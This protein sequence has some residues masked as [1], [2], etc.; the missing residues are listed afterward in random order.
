MA[1]KVWDILSADRTVVL[2]NRSLCYELGVIAVDAQTMMDDF[3]KR[4]KEFKHK[5]EIDVIY[6]V[7]GVLDEN[8]SQIKGDITAAGSRGSSFQQR[9]LKL[10]FEKDLNDEKSKF[11]QCQSKVYSISLSQ[12]YNTPGEES[13]SSEGKESAVTVKDK[14]V[15]ISNQL[16]ELRRR[17]L[18]D[19]DK[20]NFLSNRYGSIHLDTNNKFEDIS[21]LKA[22]NL[23]SPSKAG[24]STSNA[25]NKL[26]VNQSTSEAKIATSSESTNKPKEVKSADFFAVPVSTTKKQLDLSV[27]D[28]KQP[29]T[30]DMEIED[31]THQANSNNKPKKDNF[32]NP[33]KKSSTIESTAS[34]SSE[35]GTKQQ[36]SKSKSSGK[37]TIDS[38]F[39]LQKKSTNDMQAPKSDTIQSNSSTK[40]DSQEKVI[41]I[42]TP[43]N[44]K[45]DKKIVT[46][47]STPISIHSTSSS[48]DEKPKK[49]AISRR[50]ERT[51]PSEEIIITKKETKAIESEEEVESEVEF[52]EDPATK[53]KK[54][55]EKSKERLKAKS[56]E[57][58]SKKRSSMSDTEDKSDDSDEEVLLRNSS[59]KK[60]RSSRIIDD[61][62]DIHVETEAEKLE[63]EE[64]ERKKQEK[65]EQKKRI[66]EDK[67]LRE[68]EE[69]EMAKKKFLSSLGT[70]KASNTKKESEKS[71][72][73]K[74][75]RVLMTQTKIDE[76]GFE[77]TEDVWVEVPMDQ[78]GEDDV[79]VVEQPKNKIQ[80]VS[81]PEEKNKK[82]SETQTQASATAA[83][84]PQK[85]ATNES[86]QR[87]IQSFFNKR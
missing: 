64:K 55:K 14:S 59:A 30:D 35:S 67:K 10:V 34:E 72:P 79:E 38:M 63:K 18:N 69:G 15:L 56:N 28:S 12:Q 19:S 26:T 9:C 81:Q 27:N 62:N 76:D 73:V 58:S 42:L 31:Q 71:G 33:V 22:A 68:L 41:E 8:N 46:I 83:K 49:E 82:E 2:T 20:E 84:K 37:A 24:T 5:D 39:G 16:C 57:G 85:A 52:G 66:E 51:K 44:T 45:Q 13:K 87:G 11:K 77:C 54:D 80:Q 61:S 4:R 7:N 29:K 65:K 47:E 40:S 36:A 3:A 32:F 21:L 60:Q 70:D 53:P 48:P 25:S 23:S 6:A 78:D 17:L 75:K 43:A 74:M 1:E 50:S 86:K